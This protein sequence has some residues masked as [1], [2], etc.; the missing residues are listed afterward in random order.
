MLSADT[1]LVAVDH[2]ATAD[3]GG[4]AVVLD[5]EAGRYFGLNEVAARILRLVSEPRS[6]AEI[7][8]VLLSEYDVEPERLRADLMVFVQQMAERRLIKVHHATPAA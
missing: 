7:E 4:E 5:A 3:L 6:I 8:A 1:C 2:I